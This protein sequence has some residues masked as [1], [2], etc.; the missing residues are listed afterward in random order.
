[1][2]HSLDAF[3]FKFLLAGSWFFSLQHS[4]QQLWIFLSQ[5]SHQVQRAAV[6]AVILTARLDLREEL[7]IHLPGDQLAVSIESVGI[8]VCD[9]PRL[10]VTRVPLAL[11]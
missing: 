7:R 2:V 1:M 3:F 6:R 9:H 11:P 4:N 8:R 5:R 10:G